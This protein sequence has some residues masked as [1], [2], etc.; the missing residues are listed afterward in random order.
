MC[1]SALGCAIWLF[2]PL[3]KHT[4]NPEI[5][6][7]A[8]PEVPEIHVEIQRGEY[9]VSCFF[10]PFLSPWCSAGLWHPACVTATERSDHHQD[11]THKAPQAFYS[12]SSNS[13]SVSILGSLR[14]SA[15]LRRW[16]PYVVLGLFDAPDGCDR[17][18]HVIW[19]GGDSGRCVGTLVITLVRSGGRIVCL[20]W[21]RLAVRS[22][23]LR[24]CWWSLLMRLGLSE[25]LQRWEGSAQPPSSQNAGGPIATF[26][27]CHFQ[28]HGDYRPLLCFVLTRGLGVGLC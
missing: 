26:Q 21:C 15:R 11:R 19:R 5:T 27:G 18:F 7:K 24:T 9:G 20:I 2:C 23:V 3:D 1:Y 16:N 22:M 13:N 8:I 10:F 12:N 25:I 17:T 4:P 28:I 14:V 6:E